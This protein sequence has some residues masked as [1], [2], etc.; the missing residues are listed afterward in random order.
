MIAA[1]VD[2]EINVQ[3]GKFENVQ[4]IPVRHTY[5]YPCTPQ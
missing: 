4:I 3:M 1:N 2:K 5:N